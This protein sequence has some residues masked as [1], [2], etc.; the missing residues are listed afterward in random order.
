MKRCLAVDWPLENRVFGS[1]RAPNIPNNSGSRLP[2]LSMP[3][4]LNLRS[5]IWWGQPVS[6]CNSTIFYEKVSCCGMATGNQ[7]CWRHPRVKHAQ[8][9]WFSACISEPAHSIE[10]KKPNLMQPTL[11][12]PQQHNLWWKGV[13]LWN[14]H[15]KPELLKENARQIHPTTLVLSSHFWKWALNWVQG[16]SS[17]VP[18]L[19]RAETQLVG[20]KH[21]G[22]GP[23]HR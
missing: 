15:W 5:L 19:V 2:F 20:L 21:S 17:G 22:G 4:E 7:S 23:K 18:N 6:V 14:G 3:I 16:V 11:F 12:S 13:L 9:L 8:Q 10:S 1:T